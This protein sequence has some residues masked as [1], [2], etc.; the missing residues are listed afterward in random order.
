LLFTT[1]C[2]IETEFDYMQKVDE[3]VN[4][5]I[6]EVD[7]NDT[8]I[9]KDLNKDEENNIISDIL[10]L[11]CYEYFNDPCCTI[12][13]DVVKITYSNGNYELISAS[14]CEYFTNGKGCFRMIYFDTPA[15]NNL[16]SKYINGEELNT[17]IHNSYK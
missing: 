14:S 15:F 16:I 10:K 5:E 13:G 1:G 4:I 2:E 8:T 17:L 9:K 12:S 11:K 7:K 3:I 6:V